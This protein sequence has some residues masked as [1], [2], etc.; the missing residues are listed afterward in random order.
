MSTV[1]SVLGAL[2]IIT[3]LIFF[4]ELG[5]FLAGRCLGFKVDEFALGMGPVLLSKEKGGTRYAIRALPIGGM[6]MFHG[7]DEAAS[8]PA[9]FNAQPAWKRLIVVAAGPL[10][11]VLLAIVVSVGILMA[12][13]EFMP[14]VVGFSEDGFSPALEAGMQEGDI[15]TRVGDT[16]ITY[17]TECTAAIAGA[18]GGGTEVTVSRNGREIVLNV[19]DIYDPETGANRLGIYISPVRL[20]Y[21]LFEAVGG[22]LRYVYNLVREMFTVLGSFVTEGVEQGE[23]AGP[24]GTISIMG[25]AVR[26]GLEVALRLGALISVNLAVMNI[27]PLPALDG[28]RLVFIV[29]E[30]LR[31]KPI[32]PEKE[33][34]VH[35]AGLMLLF[36]LMILLTFMDIRSLV[37]GVWM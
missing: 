3:V 20:R 8:D 15:I 14:G 22:S 16:G 18:D 37:S 31:G 12:Y 35:F 23:V 25:Q 6:C 17:Y 36:G 34:M 7:E 10:M 30:L 19:A 28:G 29:I 21:G 33:G 27:L 2:L 13:G 4:H 11:N 26:A 5:H 32:S 9:C 24:V 1:I